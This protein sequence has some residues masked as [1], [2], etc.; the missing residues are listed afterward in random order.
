MVEI[1]DKLLNFFEIIADTVVS[2]F[3]GLG[4]LLKALASV[5]TVA[6]GIGVWMPASLA[7]IVT[8]IFGIALVLR[9]VGR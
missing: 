2:L 6:G 1:F 3:E 8:V 5:G 7:A 4:T 9:V